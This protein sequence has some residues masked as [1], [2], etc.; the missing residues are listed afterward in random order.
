ML[1][2]QSEEDVYRELQLFTYPG[3]FRKS[4]VEHETRIAQW[5][6]S[7]GLFQTSDPRK[8][9]EELVYPDLIRAAAPDRTDM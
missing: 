6:A 5:G 4:V 1:R 3:D 2:A 7:L 9:V 8:L